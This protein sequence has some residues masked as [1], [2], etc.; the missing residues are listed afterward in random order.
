MLVPV[1]HIIHD[2]NIL[3]IKKDFSVLL[4]KIDVA[5][6]KDISLVSG[7][8]AY[9]QYIE[10]VLKTQ[11]GE[12]TSDMNLGSNYFAYIFDGQANLAGLQTSLA[13]YIQAS[14]PSIYNVSV[15]TLYASTDSFQFEVSYSF[16]DGIVKQENM[17]TMVEVSL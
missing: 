14:I 15:N 16:T 10:V 9:A 17:T 2:I 5:G 4:E 13:G 7:F 11:K 12:L 3:M 1:D 8:N 6:N